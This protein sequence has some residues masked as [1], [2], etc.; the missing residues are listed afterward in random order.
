[1]D[2][3]CAAQAAHRL[4]RLDRTMATCYHLSAQTFACL[5]GRCCMFLD[6]GQDRYLSVPREA[7]EE[8]APWIG[9]WH[10]T[11]T[12]SPPIVRPGDAALALAAELLEAG[13]LVEGVPRPSDPA[14]FTPEADRDLLSVTPHVPRE[15]PSRHPF[16]VTAA[17]ACASWALRTTPLI[18]IV[19]SIRTRKRRH[20]TSMPADPNRTAQLV[21][22]F[23]KFRP[24]FPRNYRCLFDS[25]ALIRFLSRFDLY[26]DWVFGVQDDPFSAH[27]WVQAD[28]MVLND[29][30]DHIR[31]YTPIMTV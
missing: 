1:M 13:L 12:L 7:M 25:L 16:A 24:F 28:T 11:P 19:D 30:L 8:L 4:A 15:N 21:A 2:S 29:H 31:C 22:T 26:P 5:S 27:C 14:H 10:L 23:M 6:L 17:L 9:G 18:R 20:P 3:R